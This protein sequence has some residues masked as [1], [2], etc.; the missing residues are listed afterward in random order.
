MGEEGDIYD[1]VCVGGGPTGI[2][3]TYCMAKLGKKCL[4]IERESDIGGCHRVER[5]DGLFTEHSPHIYTNSAVNFDMLLKDMGLGSFFKE[6]LQPFRFKVANI[7]GGVTNHL[8]LWELLQLVV[9]FAHVMI[10]PEAGSRISLD[11]FARKR[12]FSKKAR[13]Y[14]DR[15]CLFTDGGGSDRFSL[16]HFIRIIDQQCRHSLFQLREPSDIGL[17]AKIKSKLL[18]TGKI[19][20]IT[21]ANVL[22]LLANN[23]RIHAAKI[24]QESGISTVR[25]KQFILA[26]P[27]VALISI[28]RGSSVNVQ[29]AFGCINAL[30][31]W[32][33]RCMYN[34]FIAITFHWDY[35][36]EPSSSNSFEKATDWHVAYLR[37][38]NY[39][40][41][42]DPRSKTVYSI[43][44]ARTDTQSS[45]TGKTANESSKEEL[46]TEVYRQL[47]TV[48]P[49]LPNP[50]YSLLHPGLI[51]RGGKWIASD[52]AYL[53]TWNSKHLNPQSP[54]FS[55]LFS[56]GSHNKTGS[57]R[58]TSIESATTAGL[59][60]VH[61]L[62]PSEENR[63]VIGSP[64]TITGIFL[65]IWAYILL[66]MAFFGF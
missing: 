63:W 51:R 25:G 8:T 39:M 35:V 17:F 55:N 7:E 15:V 11:A 29:R 49:T 66:L 65:K 26:V 44:I 56:V 60:L 53:N 46:F 40:D 38:S 30:E 4:I 48:F 45:E 47:R 43:C 64:S 18:E 62:E 21:H 19:N 16:N 23:T 20:I 41:L 34:Q 3:F 1:Y 31:R 37:L 14:L 28:L 24:E 12:G 42:G 59:Q 50:T 6:F 57:L 9:P 58:I 36:L 61:Q 27:P 5:V 32:N 13:E 2:A 33:D 52:S 10:S 22:K 54:I